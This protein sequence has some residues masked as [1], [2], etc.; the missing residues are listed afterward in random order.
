MTAVRRSGRDER[1][2]GLGQNFLQTGWADR[3]LGT[4]DLHQGQLVVE[5]G[6]GTGSLTLALADLGVRVIAVEADPV[7]AERLGRLVRET[8]RKS[9]EVVC[10][11][12]M[13][14]RLPEQPFRVM[15]SPPFGITTALLHLLLDDPSSALVRADLIVQWE[16]AL[17]RSTSPPT[18]LLS[19]SWAPWWTFQ[20]GQRLPAA[21]FRP[22]PRVDG[23]V[24]V[25]NCGLPATWDHLR[26]F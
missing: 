12:F 13:S 19:T 10:G 16:V 5:V 3:F 23:G 21:A 26:R 24:L 9:V 2:R 17:K 14:F 6:A 7:W 25:I 18:N 1:R 22:V 8:K 11:D 20:T 4:A 15:A